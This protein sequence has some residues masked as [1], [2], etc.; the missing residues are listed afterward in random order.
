MISKLRA[1]VGGAHERRADQDGV[2]P[3]ELSSSGLRPRLDPAFR[4]DDSVARSTCDE[5]ELSRA[6]DPEA[7][8]VAGVDPDRVAA[9]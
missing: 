9:E 4:D 2:R 8:E 5:V 1:W 3:G 6:V 7:R